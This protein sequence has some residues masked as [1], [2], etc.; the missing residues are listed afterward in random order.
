MKLTALGVYGP[1]PVAGGGCSSYLIEDGDTHILLD[2]GSGAL[3]RMLRHIPL[4][5]L[6]AVVLS[7]MHADHAGEIDLVRYALEFGQ[8]NTLMPVFSPE[9]AS[10]KREAFAPVRTEDGMT[11]TVGSLSLQFFAVRHAVPTTGVR[12][13]DA[14]GRALFYTGDTAYFDGLIDMAKDADLL[15][16]DACL[17]DESNPKALKN[18]MTGE[19]AA[20]LGRQANCGQVL[21][22]HRFGA[23]PVYPL[24][25][26]ASNCAFAEEGAVYEI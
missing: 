7:H 24:P 1:F 17:A 11:A 26:D 13:T 15:L 6:D 4:S 23:N 16:A 8:G 12:I 19:Q 20:N 9:T 25:E 5:K 18:H 10:L 3:S 14:N 22:T 21:F 2:C